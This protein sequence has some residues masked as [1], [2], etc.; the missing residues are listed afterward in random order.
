MG[1]DNE[2]MERQ[3]AMLWILNQAD[4]EHS[5]LDIAERSGIDYSRIREVAELLN[6]HELIS[7]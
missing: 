7:R 1:G 3:M 2:R 6:E 4:G 5:L